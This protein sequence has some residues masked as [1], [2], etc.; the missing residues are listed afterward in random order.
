MYTLSSH[1]LIFLSLKKWKLEDVLHYNG[2]QHICKSPPRHVTDIYLVAKE[3]RA[4]YVIDMEVKVNM[5]LVRGMTRVVSNLLWSLWTQR[6]LKKFLSKCYLVWIY[7]IDGT[8]KSKIYCFV[9]N[10]TIVY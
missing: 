3:N 9:N 6:Y 8:N 1:T 7:G 4:R 10:H 5:H 2:H